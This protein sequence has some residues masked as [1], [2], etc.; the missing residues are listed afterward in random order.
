ML[1]WI[2]KH[3]TVKGLEM[4]FEVDRITLFSKRKDADFPAEGKDSLMKMKISGNF[5][6]DLTFY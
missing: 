6:R 3:C 5:D 2:E 1:N 4:T